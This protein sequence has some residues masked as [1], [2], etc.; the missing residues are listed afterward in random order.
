MKGDG[1]YVVV[2]VVRY[3][4]TRQDAEGMLQVMAGLERQ[5]A[6]YSAREQQV[7]SGPIRGRQKS[8]VLVS[9]SSQLYSCG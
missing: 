1:L 2:V 9:V 5:L 3:A 7:R 8:L 4:S 6:D